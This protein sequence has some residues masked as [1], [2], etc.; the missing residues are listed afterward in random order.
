MFASEKEDSLLQRATTAHNSTALAAL[1][2]VTELRKQWFLLFS[3]LFSVIFWA[4]AQPI[5]R[6]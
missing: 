5:C 2:S 6:V 3:F 1:A 4:V